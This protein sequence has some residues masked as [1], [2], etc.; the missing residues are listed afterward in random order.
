[1][2]YHLFSG[3]PDIIYCLLRR[4]PIL[5]KPMLLFVLLFWFGFLAALAAYGNSQAR[6]QT[7]AGIVAC[8]TAVAIPDS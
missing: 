8:A 5:L 3:E 1:M 2:W 4:L 6:D 7:C